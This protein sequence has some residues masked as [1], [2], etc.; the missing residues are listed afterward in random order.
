[1][2]WRDINRRIYQVLQIRTWPVH[3]SLGRAIHDNIVCSSSQTNERPFFGRR[4]GIPLCQA[5]IFQ[6]PCRTAQFLQGDVEPDLRREGRHFV[7]KC[8]D[9]D[10]KSACRQWALAPFTEPF[11]VTSVWN[12]TESRPELFQQYALPFGARSTVHHFN[13]VARMILHVILSD[14]GIEE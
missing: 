11:A 2:S 13:W 1:M 14:C 7:V 3:S 10:L 6:L 8:F 12:P 9:F 5:I 4:I